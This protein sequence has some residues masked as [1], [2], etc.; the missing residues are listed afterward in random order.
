MGPFWA[1]PK[2]KSSDLILFQVRLMRCNAVA[3]AAFKGY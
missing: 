3:T 1:K 2:S